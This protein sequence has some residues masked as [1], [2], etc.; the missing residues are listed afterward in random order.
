ML[1]SYALLLS[2]VFISCFDGL[3]PI[4]EE[5]PPDIPDIIEEKPPDYSKYYAKSLNLSIDHDINEDNVTWSVTIDVSEDETMVGHYALYWGDASG[6]IL[7]GNETPVGTYAPEGSDINDTISSS[8][9][10]GAEYLLLYTKLTDNNLSVKTGSV[11]IEDLV[12]KRLTDINTSG[13]SSIT[14]PVI[15]NGKLYFSAY[16]GGTYG[17]EM[18]CYDDTSGLSGPVT[19]I[20]PSGS[21]SVNNLVLYNNRIYF[22]ADNPV[23]GYELYYY[24]GSNTFLVS[25]YL[26]GTGSLYPSDLTVCADR[27]FFTGSIGTGDQLLCIDTS[28]NFTEI[29]VN[30][31]ADASPSNLYSFNNALFFNANASTTGGTEK[32]LYKYDGALTEI[33]I[34]GYA[35][36]YPVGFTSYNGMLYFSAKTALYGEELWRYDGVS[37][38]LT[39]DIKPGTDSS[40]PWG[41]FVYKNRLYLSADDGNGDGRELWY[42]SQ[43]GMGHFNLVPGSDGSYPYDE[44]CEFNGYMFFTAYTTS[45][46]F[47]LWVYRGTGIPEMITDLNPGTSSSQIEEFTVYNNR[48]Y[49]IADDGVSGDELW[50]L[51]FK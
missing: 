9:P 47:E 51:Y 36:P 4:T 17:R 7:G 24:D 48:L 21:S 27:L 3:G 41:L 25:D 49:F 39:A 16:D 23:T 30:P 26:T 38:E 33:S 32:R 13:S 20:N 14:Y 2:F 50:V 28:H 29:I 35:N 40:L 22:S 37:A 1:L 45:T 46:N 34:D 19:D 10:A 31:S 5:K 11:I 42:Y 12:I 6:N 8:V 18:W 15:F 43:E 44:K